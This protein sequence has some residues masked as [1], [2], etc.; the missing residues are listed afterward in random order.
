MLRSVNIPQEQILHRKNVHFNF[1]Y[2]LYPLWYDYFV[3]DTI[4]GFDHL[5]N[6]IN[7]TLGRIKFALSLAFCQR[8]FAQKVFVD[9]ADDVV[10]CV[11]CIDFVDFVQQR[12]QLCRVDVGP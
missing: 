3:Q 6:Q 9:S 2:L 1:L 5:G 4:V 12:G 7:T 10:F 11:T 8:K